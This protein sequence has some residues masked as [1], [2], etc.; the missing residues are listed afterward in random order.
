M[1]GEHLERQARRQLAPVNVRPRRALSHAVACGAG[2]AALEGARGGVRSE[3]PGFRRRVR[4]YRAASL[5]LYSGIPKAAWN[6]PELRRVVRLKEVLVRR[7]AWAIVLCPADR[8][9]H[10]GARHNAGVPLLNRVSVGGRF[11]LRC[12]VDLRSRRPSEGCNPSR[13]WP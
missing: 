4:R 5:A 9:N 12:G 11:R 6:P 3:E 7:F 13:Q 10:S 1:V 2:A 8:F